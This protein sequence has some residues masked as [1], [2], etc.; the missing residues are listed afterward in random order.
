MV[1]KA[2]LR[3]I[4]QHADVA[5]STVSQVL[6]NKPNVSSETRQRVLEAAAELGYQP[7]TVA[8]PAIS[9]ASR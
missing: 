1:K 4:A 8:P 9:M 6:N 3:D 5:V 7:R 2:T